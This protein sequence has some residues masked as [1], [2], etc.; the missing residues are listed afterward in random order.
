MA[1]SRPCRKTRRK[2]SEKMK[3]KKTKAYYAIKA[4]LWC[5][6][7]PFS[8][9]METEHGPQKIYDAGK[10]LSA[11]TIEKMVEVDFQGVG[12][13]HDGTNEGYQ[14]E[15]DFWRVITRI[16]ARELYTVDAIL[17]LK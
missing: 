12:V 10:K 6:R 5:D 15:R 13:A 11:S 7:L 17:N 14:H 2:N 16:L 3:P 1:H 8:L 9:F 4:H